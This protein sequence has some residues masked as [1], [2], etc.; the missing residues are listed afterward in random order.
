MSIPLCLRSEG[1]ACVNLEDAVNIRVIPLQTYEPE[2]VVALDNVLL[3]GIEAQKAPPT[4]IYYRWKG[5]TISLSYAQSIEDV[6]LDKVREHGYTLVRMP[7]GGD[8]V[9]HHDTHD[10]SY[11]LIMPKHA[12]PLPNLNNPLHVYEHLCAKIVNALDEIGIPARVDQ[13]SGVYVG[14]TKVCGNASRLTSKSVLL[15]GIILHKKSEDSRVHT[16]L[17]IMTR[18]SQQDYAE[19]RNLLS[20]LDAYAPQVSVKTIIT[21]LTRSLTNNAYTIGS[22]TKEEQT[23]AQKLYNQYKRNPLQTKGSKLRG[24]CWLSRRE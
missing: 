12:L 24:L 7:S 1:E 21:H 20:G 9:F 17:D 6:H 23:K 14:N 8:A 15:Q 11:T 16:M 18:Y 13:K 5:K 19:L 22:L 4:L 2:M 3:E 10:F